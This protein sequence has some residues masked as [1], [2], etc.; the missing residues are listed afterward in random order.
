MKKTLVFISVL[1]LIL[2]CSKV[3]ENAKFNNFIGQWKI[4]HLDSICY[5]SE[6]IVENTY[7]L[8]VNGL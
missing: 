8:P 1:F 2:S 6:A 4:D 5:S 7:E 3:K